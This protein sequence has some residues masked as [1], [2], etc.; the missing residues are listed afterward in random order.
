MIIL[1]FSTKRTRVIDD[2]S[3]YFTVHNQ[4]IS[5]EEKHALQERE[6]KLKS[7]KHGRSDRKFTL[8]FAGRKVVEEDSTLGMYACTRTYVCMCMYIC[9][10]I[11][12]CVC[13]C[14]YV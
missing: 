13:M 2:E 7:Q 6:D 4:W 11:I 1:C 14:M 8:D 10:C 12:I 5:Q 9:V 3:D